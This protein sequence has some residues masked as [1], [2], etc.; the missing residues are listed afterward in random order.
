MKVTLSDIIIV[1][2]DYEL[3]SSACS[4]CGAD[5]AVGSAIIATEWREERAIVRLPVEGEK[6]PDG[7]GLVVRASRQQNDGADD[8][9]G[10]VELRCS[11]CR[12]VIIRGRAVV[13]GN[14]AG[15]LIAT[16]ILSEVIEP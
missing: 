11:S 14:N 15:R 8:G 9:S 2:R 10:W 7:G 3:E 1:P 16:R 6:T 12:H 13:A 4:S 5:L